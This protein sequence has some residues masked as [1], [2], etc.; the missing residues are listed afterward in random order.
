MRGIDIQNIIILDE[1][2]INK[3]AAGEVIERPASVVKELIENSIDANAEKIFV[4][5]KEGGK[6]F[7]KVIDDGDGMSKEDAE[8][9]WQRHSTSKIKNIDDLFS[10]RTLGF[11]GEALAS[12]AAVSKLTII[13]KPKKALSGTKI[14]VE[15]GKKIISE[16]YGCPEG[17]IVEVKELFFN[18]PARKKYLK[19]TEQELSHIADI[20]TR[21]ALIHHKVHFRLSHH[22]KILLDSPATEDSLTNFTHIYGKDA[23]KQMLRVEHGDDIRI[24]GYISKPSLTRST[25]N[26]QSVYVNRRYIKKNSGISE[27]I[28]DAYKTLVMVNRHPVVVLDVEI[29]PERAD[30]NVHPQKSEIRIKDTKGIY[31][32]VFSAVRETIRK[33]NL[34]PEVLESTSKKL[35]DF[36][37]KNN[38]GYHVE[39]IKQKLLVKE[40]KR[41]EA[42][43][44]PELNVLG[45]INKTYILAEITGNLLLID[46]HAAAER[47]LY[48]KFTEELKN[49]KVSIQKLLEP[50]IIEL[51]PKQFSLSLEK[52]ELLEGMGYKTEE[53][54]NNTIIIRTIPVLLGRNFD[55]KIFMDFLD[56]LGKLGKIESL[57]TIFH[58]RIARMAC[59]TAIKAGDEITLPQ[60][61]QYI[62]ELVKKNIP[63][64]CP[65]GRPIMITWSFYELEKMF[66]RVV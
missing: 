52:K 41:A 16:E 26:E 29:E 20:V 13:T 6:S 40:D 60:I 53:F 24:T 7:I 33:N 54:G 61:K 39:D 48:E 11:R 57:A 34:I 45:I 23:A 62:R 4:E 25:R 47:I 66:K 27:A 17:T 37:G 51:P 1:A 15:G 31:D 56:E 44:L 10:V 65:H 22:E 8:L 12:I 28:R 32:A 43:L 63:Y 58:N 46:Q 59:R 35:S 14:V 49:K 9:S 5:V 3:I 2:L 30:V 36:S 64:T 18:T 21:Y 55:K 42:E 38:S 19:S 50:V